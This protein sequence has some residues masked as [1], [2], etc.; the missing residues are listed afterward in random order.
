E[1]TLLTVPDGDT[2]RTD[3]TRL[4]GTAVP[5]GAGVGR[6][7]SALAERNRGDRA[8]GRKVDTFF[9]YVGHGDTDELGR[10]YLTLLGGRLDQARLYEEVVDRLEADY[11]HVLVDACQAAGVV[12][13]R[14]ADPRVL[15][16]LRQTLA[17]EQLSHRPQ[18]GALFAESDTG[19]T[20]EWSQIRAG[21]FSHAV[22]SGL[23]GGADVNRDG[24]VTY[25]ELEAFVASAI[26]GIRSPRARL[27][28]RTFPPAQ[29]PGRSLVGP[30]PDGPLLALPP[31]QTFDRLSVEDSLGVRLA[32]AHRASGEALALALPQR[33]LYWLRTPNGDVRVSPQQLS[34]PPQRMSSP[35]LS[36]RGVAEES[37]VRGFFAAPYG[38]AFYEG[39]TASVGSLPVEF[40]PPLAS[41]T[42]SLLG[43]PDRRGLGLTLGVS[44]ADAPLRG[45]GL[46]GGLSLAWRSAGAFY[47]GLRGAYGLAPQAWEDRANLQRISLLALGGLRGSGTWAPF[48]EGGAGWLIAIVNRP[49]QTQGDAAAFTGRVAAGVEARAAGWGFRLGAGVDLDSVRV[50]GSRRLYGVPGVELGLTL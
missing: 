5:D 15:R 25:S 17:E 30:V 48:V 19:E 47:G 41:P 34:A 7:V 42:S 22:R 24:Q 49:E 1:T 14:G 23:L 2:A 9:I 10:A 36:Q 31:N 44:V 29:D 45:R 35:E 16:Q 38:R 18:A 46:A 3:G 27:E 50:E 12:G 13:R 37:L 4:R 32:D 26:R 20:H 40:A 33:D 39:F 11:V 21:V 8:A 28:V 6:A 43:S